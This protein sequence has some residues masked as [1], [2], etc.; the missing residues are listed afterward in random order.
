MRHYEARHFAQ[1]DDK[2]AIFIPLMTS[3]LRRLCGLAEESLGAPA[4]K[5]SR[6]GRASSRQGGGDGARAQRKG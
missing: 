4:S 6:A 1:E 5:F 3:C 2:N